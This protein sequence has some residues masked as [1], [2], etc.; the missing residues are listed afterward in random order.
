[1]PQTTHPTSIM[2]TLA[3]ILSVMV[4]GPTVVNAG[5]KLEITL[6]PDSI[7]QWYKPQNRRQVWLHLMFRLG[8][9]SQAVAEYGKEDDPRRTAYWVGEFAKKYKKIPTMVPEWSNE[10]DLEALTAMESAAASQ[11]TAGVL[12]ALKKLRQTCKS[13]HGQYK[14]LTV[15]LYRSPD[16]SKVAIDLDGNKETATYKGFM[17]LI[18]KDLTALKIAREELRPDDAR[19]HGKELSKKLDTLGASCSNCHR[20]SQPLER[21]LGKKTK[22][23]LT[24][25]Q[26]ALQE[27]GTT[28]KSGRLLGELGYTVCGR[29]HGIHRNSADIRRLLM[30]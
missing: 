4:S 16:F 30:N 25:L 7:A 19:R 12:S 14:G 27:P 3:I 9:T 20:D 11:N 17:R 2:A 22:D 1:M 13:C 6:P 21:I 29:C 24:A 10:V 18:H 5:E 26:E 23:T 8:Q 15:A 28:K